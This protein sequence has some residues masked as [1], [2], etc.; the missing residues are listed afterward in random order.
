LA[1]LPLASR[2]Q[3]LQELAQAAQLLAVGQRPSLRQDGQGPG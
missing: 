3:A 2:R 1:A